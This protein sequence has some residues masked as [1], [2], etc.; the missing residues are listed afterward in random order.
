MLSSAG[1]ILPGKHLS[2]DDFNPA[3]YFEEDNVVGINSDIIWG[4]RGHWFLPPPEIRVY[5]YQRARIE[6]VLGWLCG[7]DGVA[8][9]KDPRGTLT[10][11][12]WLEA[13]RELDVPVHVVG[14]FREPAAVAASIV[15]HERG[16]FN[17]TQALNAWCIHSARLLEHANLLKDR[18]HW[19]TIDQDV[20]RV[21][22]NLG[23]IADKLGLRNGVGPVSAS[24]E[25]MIAKNADV[26]GD[27]L[28]I[29]ERLTQ[30]HSAQWT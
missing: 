24:G 2:A 25:S 7:F 29:Y 23:G 1:L 10:L 9:W 6:Q 5:P 8:G 17:F 27:A 19:F 12:A 15:R 28:R 22:T 13:A 4:S 18:F 20:E 11:P 3:G 21:A 26:P 30:A 16:A 14:V